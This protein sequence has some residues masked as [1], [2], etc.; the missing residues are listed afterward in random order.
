MLLDSLCIVVYIPIQKR[1]GRAMKVVVFAASKGGVAKTTLCYNTALI[2]AE[3]S[4]VFIADLDPQRSLSDIWQRRNEF[5]NPRLITDVESVA[6]SVK[7]LTQAGYDREFMFVDTPGSMMPVITDAIMAAD[8]I[9]LPT[10]P[11]PLDLHA[12]DAV[13]ARIDKMGLSEKVM[14]V[15][16]R[17]STKADTEKAKEY[18]RLRTRFPIL[19]MSERV[20]YKRAAEKGQAAWEVSRGKE[21]KTEIS[22][23]WV[24][25]QK[26][27]KRTSTKLEKDDHA[28]QVRH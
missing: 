15:L 7:L 14:F 28:S 21:I 8:L 25:M 9:V 22:E 20:D 5:V 3:K 4:Q 18:L 19:T 13:A 24:E 27:I 10:Q 23:L 1:R 16:T 12:Q 26:A 2:A 17:T 6:K 11:S